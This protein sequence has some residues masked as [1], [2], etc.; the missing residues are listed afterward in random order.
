[1]KRSVQTAHSRRVTH[2]DGRAG[3]SGATGGKDALASASVRFASEEGMG[4]CVGR[5]TTSLNRNVIPQNM[6]VL[7]VI[8]PV[9]AGVAS[10]RMT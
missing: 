1:M 9:P 2:A 3:I 6:Y 10:L 7:S 4:T 8:V 5:R